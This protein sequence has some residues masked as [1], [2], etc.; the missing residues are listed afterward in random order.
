QPIFF[1]R[2]LARSDDFHL[3]TILQRMAQ[4]HE[5]MIYFCAYASRSNVGVYFECKIQ[6]RCAIWQLHQSAL[7][8][9]DENF[10]RKEVHFEVVH[11]IKCALFGTGK[12]AS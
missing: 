11:E 1:W 3:V 12:Q 10:V 4:W 7:W 9:E 6:S 8:R 2:L 5:F